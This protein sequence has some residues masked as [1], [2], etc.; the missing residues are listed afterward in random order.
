MQLQQGKVIHKGPCQ[1]KVSWTTRSSVLRKFESTRDDNGIT[2][3]I[4]RGDCQVVHGDKGG[5]VI[6]YDYSQESGCFRETFIPQQSN[7]ISIR[8]AEGKLVWESP[9]EKKR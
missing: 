6:Q 2:I 7:L 3:L 1:V 4:D 5:I 9:K 8:D